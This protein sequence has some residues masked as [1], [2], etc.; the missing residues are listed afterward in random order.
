MVI[1]SRHLIL[2]GFVSDSPLWLS[3]HY[4]AGLRNLDQGLWWVT[5]GLAGGYSATA[6][7]SQTFILKANGAAVKPGGGIFWSS[8]SSR[9][10]TGANARMEPGDTIVVPDKL[11]KVAWM[12]NIKDLTTVL[13]QIA[14]GTGV[15][16]RL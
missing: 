1:Y 9:W 8:A 11:D 10:Q 5:I 16:L 6:D 3:I 15:L 14:V 7:N 4:G 2:P 13:Y 12:R